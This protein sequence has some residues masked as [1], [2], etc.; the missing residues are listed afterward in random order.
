MKKLPSLFR[1]WLKR[2]RRKKRRRRYYD[3]Y[4]KLFWL[5]SGKTISAMDAVTQTQAVVDWFRGL[6][7]EY[8]DVI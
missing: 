3:L 5:Y 6:D 8:A 1:T 2:Y 4:H 7:E